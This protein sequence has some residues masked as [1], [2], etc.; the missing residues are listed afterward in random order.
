MLVG[1]LA[2]TRL[3]DFVRVYRRVPFSV[4]EQMQGMQADGVGTGRLGTDGGV[5]RIRRYQIP[6]FRLIAIQTPY[7]AQLDS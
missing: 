1:N 4:R 3:V 7:C 2:E 6:T 5:V